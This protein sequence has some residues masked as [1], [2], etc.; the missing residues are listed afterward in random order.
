MRILPY[1]DLA[2]AQAANAAALQFAQTTQG[3]TGGQWS[4]IYT[5][6]VRFGILYDD[7]IAPAFDA[8]TLATVMDAP[9]T[10]YDDSGNVTTP[11]WAVYVPPPINPP[12]Q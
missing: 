3:A 8:P 1:N 7:S 4:D 2:S 12:T 6:G 11:G 5:D 9:P 10:V